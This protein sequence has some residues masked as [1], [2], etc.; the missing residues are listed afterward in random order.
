MVVD[1]KTIAFT[2]TDGWAYRYLFATG[3]IELLIRDYKI[4]LICTPF[5][6][7]LIE[8]MSRHDISIIHI[9]DAGKLSKLLISFSNF[10]YRGSFH[11]EI[12]NFYISKYNFLFRF[13]YTYF[14]KWI[15]TKYHIIFL[16]FS[17][18]IL[19]VWVTFLYPLRVNRTYDKIVFL[20]PY[21]ADEI[22]LSFIFKKFQNKIFVLPS[23]DNIYKYYLFDNFNKYVVWGSA[24]E[25]FLKDRFNNRIS[26]LGNISHFKMKDLSR[27]SITLKRNNSI[28][29]LYCTVTTR[30]FKNE[31]FFVERL[32][33]LVENNF[34]GSDV[35][36]IIRPHPADRN[37]SSYRSS[38]SKRI[39]ISDINSKS[40]SQRV[41]RVDNFNLLRHWQTD[42]IFFTQLV[43]DLTTASVVLNVASTITLDAIILK[44]FTI[45]IRP[46]ECYHNSD[47]Y[48]FKHYSPI[49]LSNLVPVIQEDDI[50]KL[51]KYIEAIRVSNYEVICDQ[52]SAISSLS[53]V[54]DSDNLENYLNLVLSEL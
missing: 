15:L 43:E 7:K 4:E 21:Y 19:R 53:S 48:N 29:I 11:N 46:V 54:H 36:L 34:F 33:N 49:F 2:I 1:R 51:D 25:N 38:K 18:I 16:N 40:E 22:V 30:I 20:S 14:L 35:N 3:A 52:S 23:W 5:Y 10:V 39:V 47:Y 24:Q 17:S 13:I 32:K 41:E 50:F 44:R 37:N 26:V 12:N 8:S 9:Q 42:S 28:T 31:V 6:F 27:N 45:N